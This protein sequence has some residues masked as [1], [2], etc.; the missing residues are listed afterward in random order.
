MTY[1]LRI[2]RE[3][4]YYCVYELLLWYSSKYPAVR[5]QSWYRNA[6]DQCRDGWVYVK[7]KITM[8]DV[9]RQIESIDVGPSGVSSPVFSSKPS[10]LEGL[11]EIRLRAPWSE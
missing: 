1:P 7:T 2:M 4:L 8:D 6:I 3:Y 9:D 10:E 11:D 5:L